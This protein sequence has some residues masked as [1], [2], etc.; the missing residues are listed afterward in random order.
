MFSGMLTTV[1]TSFVVAITSDPLQLEEAL[2]DIILFGSLDQVKMVATP[3][4]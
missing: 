1:I 3:A 2:A 4:P